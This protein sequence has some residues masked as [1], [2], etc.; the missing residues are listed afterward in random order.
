MKK[1]AIYPIPE[2]FGR[3]IKMVDDVELDEAFEQ[4]VQQIDQIDI[5]ALH[6]LADRTYAPDKWTTKDILQHVCDTE[7]I[8]SYRALR[9]ARNDQTELKGFE[10][11]LYAANA[12][13]RLRSFNDLITELKT[14]RQ[15]TILLYNHFDEEMLLQK[16]ICNNIEMNALAIGFMIIG[17][18]IHHFR[19]IQERYLSMLK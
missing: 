1:S 18:Q 5:H 12:K 16:G 3:Y 14:V 8:M 13:A 17:H 10:Q 11:D 19:I 15:C 9:F 6:E 4:S 7:R 2:H